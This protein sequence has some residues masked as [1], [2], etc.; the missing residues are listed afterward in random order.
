MQRARCVG[1]LAIAA[2]IGCG[3]HTTPSVEGS[4]R[5]DAGLEARRDGDAGGDAGG[6]GSSGPL[7]GVDGGGDAGAPGLGEDRSEPAGD[8][9]YVVRL[10]RSACYGTC[11]VYGVEID[12]SGAVRYQGTRYVRVRGKKDVKI[13]P[14]TVADL[15]DKLRAAGFFRLAW[16]DPC[17][18]VATDNAT[19]TVTF[20]DG[21][22]KRTIEDYHGNMC[23]PATLRE[24]EDAIDRVA[25]TAAWTK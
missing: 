25:G 20:V 6:A 21:G 8:V 17:D 3:K 2:A 1:V 18:R 9:R 7:A 5:G 15:A 16:K 14:A 10:E 24:L 23:M 12:A 22:H 13:P 4:P 11:P 19:V